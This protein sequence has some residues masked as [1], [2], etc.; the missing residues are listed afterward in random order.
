MGS[1]RCAHGNTT[2]NRARSAHYER[3]QS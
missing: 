1:V 3:K 2:I